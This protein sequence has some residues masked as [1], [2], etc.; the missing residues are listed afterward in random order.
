MIVPFSAIPDALAIVRLPK[1]VHKQTS[2]YHRGHTVYVPHAGGYIR[3]G[4]WFDNRWATS[5]P[6]V[7]VLELEGDGIAFMD[8]PGKAVSYANG[9]E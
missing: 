6:D 8:G 7:S 5:H 9:G 4:H 2:V 1:G 3:V